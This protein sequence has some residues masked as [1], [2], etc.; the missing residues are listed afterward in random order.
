MDLGDDYLYFHIDGKN[1]VGVEMVR[2]QLPTRETRL[3]SD[4]NDGNLTEEKDRPA[5]T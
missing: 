2:K 4:P 5:I 1:I 3:V